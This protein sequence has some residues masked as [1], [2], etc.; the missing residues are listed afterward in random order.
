[1][2]LRSAAAR[3]RRR[4]RH[5]EAGPL[6]LHGAHL[7]R[8]RSFRAMEHCRVELERAVILRKGMIP[9]ELKTE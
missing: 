3:V 5:Q 2:E 1:M 9:T 8:I 4:R 7:W 6:G